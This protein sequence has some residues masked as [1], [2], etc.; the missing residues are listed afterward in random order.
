MLDEIVRAAIHP[1]IGIARVGN[2]PAE[3]FIAPEVPDPE[4]QE[5]GFYKD[6]A[7]AVKREVARF[8]VYGYN[9]TGE[10]V[11]ELTAD[12]AD[13]RWTAHLVNKK[14]AW[15]QF[16]LAL[17]IPD[18]SLARASELR[19]KEITGDLRKDLVI[20]PGPL[21]ISGKNTSGADFH[22]RDGKFMGK[23]VYLGELRTDEDGRL[24]VFGGFGASAPTTASR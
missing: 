11:A 10:V 16:Q 6:P 12:N 22:F 24:L 15:Y 9:A 4:P 18:A 8:R 20:D 1:A 21:G 3:Y 17:D 5:P 14:S 23:E 13:I 7:G 2:A 19:N